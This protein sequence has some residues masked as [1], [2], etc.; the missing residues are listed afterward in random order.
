MSSITLSQNTLACLLLIAPT[1][2]THPPSALPPSPSPSLVRAIICE[3]RP[4]QS[5]QPLQAHDQQQAGMLHWL[6]PAAE[7]STPDIRK[8]RMI[9]THFQQSEP[10]NDSM[11]PSTKH[12]PAAAAAWNSRWVLQTT[13]TCCHP[14][15]HV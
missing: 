4:M 1:S 2:A 9:P 7:V 11:Q 15:Q 6:T 3:G 10:H 14:Q 8:S 5:F 13:R 12:E